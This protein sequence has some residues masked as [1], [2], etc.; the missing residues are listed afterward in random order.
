MSVVVDLSPRIILLEDDTKFAGPIVSA[1]ESDGYFVKWLVN[2]S[3]LLDIME[4]FVPNIIIINWNSVNEG[5]LKLVTEIR[6]LHTLD[7]TKIILISNDYSSNNSIR[8]L[9][10]GA[11]DYLVK[12]IS[13]VELLARVWAHLRHW[14]IKNKNIEEQKSKEIL[15]HKPKEFEAFYLKRPKSIDKSIASKT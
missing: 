4:H 14:R 5:C 1:L 7:H 6:D 12:P 2:G 10:L 9:T 11:D 13:D 15:F 8:A 3:Y